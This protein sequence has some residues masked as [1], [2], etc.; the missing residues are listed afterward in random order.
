MKSAPKPAETEGCC[1]N[2]PVKVCHH[3]C[4]QQEREVTV[5]SADKS[6]NCQNQPVK[7]IFAPA[8]M[9]SIFGAVPG[10]PY[11]VKQPPKINEK[12]TSAAVPVVLPSSTSTTANPKGCAAAR[13]KRDHAT[14]KGGKDQSRWDPSIFVSS[15][16]AALYLW[17]ILIKSI[18]CN[19]MT[20]TE[21]DYG[22]LGGLAP[23]STDFRS[24]I[25]RGGKANTTNCI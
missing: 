22:S 10:I 5:A 16:V 14:T 19:K 7:V 4:C 18:L 21:L 1:Q 24:P 6:C 13:S 20:P 17:H 11:I 23:H 15:A 12:V 25:I 9:P 8:M 2:R 3:C